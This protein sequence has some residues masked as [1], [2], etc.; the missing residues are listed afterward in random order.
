MFA[1]LIIFHSIYF[2]LFTCL[3]CSCI[4]VFICSSNFEESWKKIYVY[5]KE[6]QVFFKLHWFAHYIR[7]ENMPSAINI[8]VKRQH[9]SYLDA[10]RSFEPFE[11][12][13]TK[14]VPNSSS[15]INSHSFCYTKTDSKCQ[16]QK[17]YQKFLE[18]E[19]R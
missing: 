9:I 18:N 4:H 10:A 12:K 7:R 11:I 8:L 19:I 6:F 15:D 17:P 2:C 14:S 13:P 1:H 5:V 16:W 3:L